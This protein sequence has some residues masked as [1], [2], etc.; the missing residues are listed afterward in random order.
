MMHVNAELFIFITCDSSL[1]VLQWSL[2]FIG[3]QS[4]KGDGE[5]IQIFTLVKRKCTQTETEICWTLIFQ[6][7][8][9]L[10]DRRMRLVFKIS[11]LDAF[12]ANH[13][14]TSSGF[15]LLLPLSLNCSHMY[16]VWPPCEGP[17][18]WRN[19]GHWELNHSVHGFLIPIVSSFVDTL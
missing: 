12:Q 11:I 9:L 7:I 1:I 17:H 14:M 8:K 15:F 4:G 2:L 10:G 6:Q 3:G 19:R 18:I 5:S 16:E 13:T